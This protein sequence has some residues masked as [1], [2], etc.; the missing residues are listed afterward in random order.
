MSPSQLTAVDARDPRPPAGAWDSTGP[1]APVPPPPHLPPLPPGAAALF[2]PRGPDDARNLAG[3]Q[4][5]REV[6][7]GAMGVVY[8]AEQLDLRRVVA[9]K[10]LHPTAPLGR[11]T[12]ARFRAEAEAA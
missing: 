3:Y 12:L 10:L 1:A 9:V 11:E 6:G 2:D 4:L 5:R 8:E 7:R